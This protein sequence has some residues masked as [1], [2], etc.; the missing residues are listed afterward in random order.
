MNRVCAKAPAARL[1]I[2]GTAIH[3]ISHGP[4]ARSWSSTMAS[5]RAATSWRTSEAVAVM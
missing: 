2:S 5:S 4:V 1:K 3:S